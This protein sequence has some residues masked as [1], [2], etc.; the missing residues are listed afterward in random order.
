MEFFKEILGFLGSPG[1]VVI[2]I[3]IFVFIIILVFKRP[4][5]SFFRTLIK[6]K[7]RGLEME[8][9]GH[10]S[11][12]SSH[13][14]DSLIESDGTKIEKVE[15]ESD[16]SAIVEVVSTTDSINDIS[17][18][19]YL[20]DLIEAYEMKDKIKLKTIY[21]DFKKNELNKISKLKLEAAYYSILYRLGEDVVNYFS[22]I[23]KKAKN[24]EAYPNVM[25]VFANAFTDMNDYDR[26]KIYLKRGISNLNYSRGIRSD[27][28]ESLTDIHFELGE[29]DMAVNL[30]LCEI[31]RNELTDENK[32][33]YYYLLS[34][35]YKKNG[36]LKL[37]VY[38]L[39]K[40]IKIKPNHKT[41]LFS[42]AYAYSEINCYEMSILYYE[43]LLLIDDKD[44]SAI[45]NLGVAYS[46]L[47]IEHE[48]IKLYKKASDLGNTLATANLSYSYM[49]AGF[50]DMAE[51]I[52][53][54]VKGRENVHKNVNSALLK[55]QRL[56]KE[57]KDKKDKK[58]ERS[59]ELKDLFNSLA[60]ARF[61]KFTITSEIFEGVWMFD[62]DDSISEITVNQNQISIISTTRKLVG[63]FVN[64]HI[65]FDFYEK[66]HSINTGEYKFEKKIAQ[67]F[68]YLDMDEKKIYV[69][70]NSVEN[71][72]KFYVIE[73]K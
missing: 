66:K 55:V 7:F 50:I 36:D 61:E 69:L 48:S 22:E 29:F 67:I 54:N 17:A 18:D 20:E 41:T 44:T 10:S 46:K 72:Y 24:T 6:V 21:H 16:S 60:S 49:N 43:R 14:G 32:F 57:E 25:L 15:S 68:G 59:K 11:K 34:N 37:Q 62:D 35:L 27:L 58:I 71:D 73:K 30:L 65:T 5:E 1:G 3:T 2:F 9:T 4:L 31:N 42:I 23:E 47:N 33:D 19:I 45:N 64:R 53:E 39:E 12:D 51:Q 40:A 28:F 26:A 8:A 13:N 63:D 52:L 38:A 56:K 70:D